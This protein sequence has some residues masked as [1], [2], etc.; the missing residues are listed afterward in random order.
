M[1]KISPSENCSV[2]TLLERDSILFSSQIR[3][4]HDAALQN[5][6]PTTFNGGPNADSIYS[7]VK[8]KSGD[9]A[10]MLRTREDFN[11]FVNQAS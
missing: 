9:P 2:V 5:D 1:Q 8:R 10:A 11:D 4:R 7:W 3:P 6:K